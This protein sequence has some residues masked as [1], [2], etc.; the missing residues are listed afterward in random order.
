MNGSDSSGTTWVTSSEILKMTGISRAT[1][2]NYIKYAIIPAPLVKRPD[3][4]DIRARKIGYFPK[5]ILERIA[6]IKRMKGEGKSM[7]HIVKSFSENSSEDQRNISAASDSLNLSIN[8]IRSP[9]YLVNNKFEIE[10]INKEAEEKVF[11]QNISLL[12]DST[13]RNV[14]KLLSGLELLKDNHKDTEFVKYFMKFYKNTYESNNLAKLFDGISEKEVHFLQK[15]Y[16]LVEPLDTNALHATYVSLCEPDGKTT[17]YN[18]YNLIFREGILIIH[19]PVDDLLQGVMELLSKRGKII[20]ELMKQRMPSL[21]SFCVLMADLQDSSRICAELPPD[22]YFELIR[23]VW[24]CM[25]G[26]FQKY[27][28][29]YGKHVGD[30][31]VY[32]F[33][34]EKDENYIM[35]SICCA[36]ELREKM[37]KLNMEWKMRKGWFN[38]LYLNIGI[39]E[40]QE[41]FGSIPSSPNIEFTALGDSVNYAGRLSDL[42]RYGAI[43]TT[44]NLIN[45]LDAVARRKVHF[46]IRRRDNE[47][48]VFIDNMFSRV[49]DML[50]QDDPKYSKFMDIATLAVTE[51]VTASQTEAT[52]PK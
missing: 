48:E 29:T 45:H 23:D 7:E 34:K 28:G 1:L 52:F 46:G 27:Y 33:L 30:G 13:E 19:A 17:A 43:W 12:K 8:D 15:I 3:D 41:F 31:M 18:V 35:N 32:Y 50:R 47:R 51:I 26:I 25:D 20:N 24:K 5:N 42:A 39:N 10:W 2:N 11:Y 14:F 36:V 21:V 44:K 4:P 16:D 38:D 40:G 9:A 37:K 49:M 22:E 6:T